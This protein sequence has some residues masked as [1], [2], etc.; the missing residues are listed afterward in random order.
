MNRKRNL[1]E[2][3]KTGINEARQHSRGHVKLKTRKIKEPDIKSIR[4][5]F[6]IRQEEFAALIGVSV[7]TLQNWEQGHRH[8]TGAARAL[9]KIVEKNPKAAIDALHS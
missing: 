2:E 3:L 1:F 4:E 7:R 9:F 5:K 6:G 8:P